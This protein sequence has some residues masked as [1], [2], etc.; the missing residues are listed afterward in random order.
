MGREEGRKAVLNEIVISDFWVCLF[1]V[2]CS[3]KSSRERAAGTGAF[4]HELE[5]KMEVALIQTK[6]K[7]ALETRLA[8]ALRPARHVRASSRFPP[9]LPP[10]LDEK[11]ETFSPLLLKE[12]L[13]R[14]FFFQ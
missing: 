1:V 13:G 4:L 3:A 8:R 14:P 10:V 6:I 2:L 12:K 7:A 11:K 5:E 9:A